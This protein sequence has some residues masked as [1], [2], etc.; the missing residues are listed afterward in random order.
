MATYNFTI[1]ATDNAGAYA[2]RTFSLNVNNTIYDRFVAVGASGLIRSPNG[3]SWTLESSLSGRNVVYGGGKWLVMDGMTLRTSPD[4]TTWTSYVPTITTNTT[5]T[6]NE[7]TT[8]KYIN[9]AWIGFL[10]FGTTGNLDL[11]TSTDGA[12]TFSKVTTVATGFL[13]NDFDIDPAGT[14]IALN[15]NSTVL[16]RDGTTGVS[17]TISLPT[18]VIAQNTQGGTIRYYNGL[19][20]VLPQG[21][22][23]IAT[24]VDGINW[25]QRQLVGASIGLMYLNG[26]IITLR[27]ANS[28]SN[29]ALPVCESTNAGRTWTAKV[30]ASGP[31]PGISVYGRSPMAYFGGTLLAHNTGNTIFRSTDEGKTWTNSTPFTT[32]TGN[33][34][35]I[36]ARDGIS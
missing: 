20:I 14:I 15:S 9:G 17:T 30:G 26:R 23:W 35:A 29:I 36:A 10:Y 21:S 22:A 25:V 32:G 7:I 2:D 28:V 24:S 31:T 5:G 3:T 16:R 4:G 33:F 6:P 34:Y 11:I 18:N 12:L 19:W 27:N 13:I 1:R 8:L